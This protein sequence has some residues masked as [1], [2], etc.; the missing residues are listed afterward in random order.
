MAKGFTESD[1]PCVLGHQAHVVSLK[2]TWHT[3]LDHFPETRGLPQTLILNMLVP[4]S[5][6]DRVTSV[7]WVD[8]RSTQLIDTI[9]WKKISGHSN[10]AGEPR[11]PKWC[12]IPLP[13]VRD[14]HE[15]VRS[16]GLPL[17]RA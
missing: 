9:R 1:R 14:A 7:I 10:I 2:Y 6:A 8:M 16:H 3:R 15:S 5:I 12:R 4:Q 11:I 17:R 13:V